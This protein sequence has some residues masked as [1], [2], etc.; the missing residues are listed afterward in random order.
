MSNG[1]RSAGGAATGA[2]MDYQA[3]V[4]AWAGVHLLAEEDAE[5]PFGLRS[6]AARIACE[7]SQPV[8][9]LM[10]TT[11]AGCVAYVQVKRSV[12]LSRDGHSM[13][14]SA[15]DQFVRQFLAA[16]AATEG[17]RDAPDAANDRIVLVVGAGAPATV[18]VTLRETLDRVRAFPGDKLS[19]DGLGVERRRALESVVQHVRSSWRAAA[20][21]DPSRRDVRELLNLVH[22]ETIEVGDGERDERSAKDILRRSVLEAPEQ[23]SEAWLVLINEGLRLIQT[24]GHADRTR[25]LTVL[26]S[27]GVGVRAPRSYRKDIRRLGNHS[28]RVTSLLAEHVSIRLGTERVRIARPYVSLLRD[29]AETGP[30]LVVGEPGAGKSGVLRSLFE[31]LREEGRQVVVLAAQQPPF[32]SPGDLRAE[33]RLDHDVVEVLANWPGTRPAFLLVDAL[34]AARTEASAAALRT[35]IREVGERTDR[36]H[37]VASMREYDARHSR[38]LALIF[39]GE[40][41]NAPVTPLAGGSF[42]RIRHMVVG[43]LTD[44]ELGQI[45]ELGALDLA[46]LL[47]SAPAPVAE[48]LHNPFN[49]R[50]VAELLESG[51]NPKAIREVGSQL[52][53]LDL[54]WQERV[55]GGGGKHDAPARQALLREAVTAMSRDR[56]L[57]V[58]QDVVESVASGRHLY[59]LLSEQVL[60][61]WKPRPEDAPRSSTFAFAHHVLFDYAVA[62]LLL[63]RDAGRLAAFLAA[64]PAFVLLGR[65]SLV[66]HFHYLWALDQ[67]GGAREEFWETALDVCDPPGIPE[68]GKLIGPGVAA[69]IGITVQEFEP[70]LVALADPDDSVRTSAENALAYCSRALLRERG[71]QP[72]ASGLLCDL[73]DRLSYTSTTGSIYPTSW[74]L[75]D[76]A[77]HDE[78]SA[79][80][81]EQLGTASRRLLVFAWTQRQRD[82]R[83]V[84][85]AIRFVCQTFATNV[86]ASAALLRQ[87]I[88]PDH[89]AQHGSEELRILADAVA[90]L[91]PHDPGFV[92]DIY[93]ASFGYSETSDAPTA[94]RR[95]VLS[96]TSNRRQDYQ[97]ALYRLVESFPAFLRAAP[98]EAVGAMNVAVECHVTRRPPLP[99][100]D[101]VVFDLDG[102]RARLLADYSHVGDWGRGRPDQYAIQLLDRVQQRLEELAN[103]Q[104]D[105]AT[106]GV[107]L[108][109]LVRTC[110]LGV[111]WRRLLGSGARYPGQIGMRIRAAGWSLPLL[112][113][114]DTITKVGEMI[115]AL[116]LDLCEAERKRIER[117]IL[118]IPEVTPPDRLRSAEHARDRLLGC[119]PEDGLVTVEARTHLYAL[120]AAD[121]IPGNEDGLT[122]Q[123]GTRAVHE[124]ELLAEQGV[125]V[126]AEPNRRLQDLERPV[127]DFA[128]AHLN[129]VPESHSLAE[130]FPHLTELHTA[131]RSSEADGIHEKQ[132]DSAWGSLAKACAAIAKMEALNCQDEEGAF[133]RAV[134]LETSKNRV[135][136]VDG[137][138]D[139]RFVEPTWG[140]PAARIEAAAG[141]V[142]I[143][144]HPSCDDSDVLA[145]VERLIVDPAPCVRYQIACRLMYPYA[146]DPEW[147]WRMIERLARDPSIG[148][149]RGLVRTLSFLRFR[150]PK[151]VASSTI[152]IMQAVADAPNRKKLSNFMCARPRRSVRRRQGCCRVCRYRR[153]C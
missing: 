35:L 24:H 52:D 141:L 39:K 104:A 106:L 29:A 53:L 5:P 23:A 95:G 88:E 10:L 54:Y 82:T 119:L 19:G 122:S 56:V 128:D 1:H 17:S 131:L 118:S 47:E 46:R 65:P 99:D 144:R 142:T 79:A 102:E 69:E 152:G 94:L 6:P 50:L 91:T 146:R 73:A 59:D 116:F 7:G 135:P 123:F 133:V 140:S 71:S 21:S 67:P 61:E 76:L 60:V 13:L 108:N 74:I 3:R 30:V 107:L 58:D 72:E 55:E 145:A 11:D 32:V 112:V 68:I 111:V 26:N 110:Q 80:Q 9:D 41:P 124:V 63:R 120:R 49:L 90:S 38:E 153:D 97:S 137:D 4:S 48:L 134:L 89:L 36:W 98:E 132:A 51:T 127:K 14:A 92:R 83:L 151:R 62:R 86:V 27:A 115:A 87:A 33:L 43:R 15:M 117:A 16:R 66:M 75:W 126:D 20:G 40:P 125:P 114:R 109:T 150:E 84:A 57:H 148:V 34:D 28:D 136:T 130:V 42:A 81:R 103:Q 93:R 105:T 121:A 70:L 64:D 37:V 8:D 22:V 2:G 147:T 78:L 113:C 85:G 31:T 138:A 44:D 139:E 101:A 18:R 100:E 12:A 96:L 149:M 143:L 25:L 77:D 129:E 45:A